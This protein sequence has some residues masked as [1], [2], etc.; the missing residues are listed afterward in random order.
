[1]RHSTSVTRSTPRRTA[2]VG[3]LAAF[4][5]FALLPCGVAAAD[6]VTTNFENFQA[7]SP[8][9]PVF[10]ATCTVNGQD[11]W[12]SALPGQVGPSLPIGYDQQVVGN[13]T[14]PGAPAPTSFGATSLRISNA[15]GTAPDTFPPEYEHQTYSKPTVPA[16]QDLTNTEYTAQFSF[17]SIHPNAEQPRLNI[18]VSPDNGHGGRM[19][20]VGLADTPTGIQITFYDTNPAGE[21][22]LYQLGTVPRNVPHTIKIW[23]RLIPGPNNDLVRISIDGKDAGHCFTTWES[24]NGANVPISDRLLLLSGNKDGNRLGL[25]NGGYLFDNVSVTTGGAG[26]PGC[27]LPIEKKAD[28][29]TVSAGGLAGYQITVRN[30]GRLSERNLLVCD[31]IPRKMTFVRAS[32]NLRRV[33]RRRCLLIPLLKPGQRETFH[34]TLRVNPNAQPGVLDN[35]AEETPVQPPNQP[36]AVTVPPAAAAD[37]PGRITQTPPPIRRVRA[38]VR[39]VPTRTRPN[40]TG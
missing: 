20:Y 10:V 2:M 30:R 33:G 15:Y 23:M 4:A 6:T 8:P 3:L 19:S 17:I 9:Q 14:I 36:P 22:V 35:T 34:L 12:K 38:A 7:C 21:W 1:M 31:R 24:S 39:V 11:G 32:R 26:P 37:V 28:S 5:G 18:T 40:F 25:L 16:G 29:P 13:A 27:D